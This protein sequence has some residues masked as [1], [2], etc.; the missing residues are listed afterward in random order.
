MAIVCKDSIKRKLKNGKVRIGY[1][2][3]D[4]LK[5]NLDYE[6]KRINKNWDAVILYD[7]EEGAAKTT[8]AC[9]NAYY[10]AEQCGSHF[11]INNIVFTQ[12]EFM[13]LV[14]VAKPY[15]NIVWD[16]FVLSGLNLEALSMLQITL[17]KKMTVIRKKRLVI[18]LIIPYMYMLTKY[19]AVA[20]TR[21]LIHVYSKDNLNR[22]DFLYF[23]KPRKRKLYIMGKKFWEYNVK[24]DFNGNFTNTFGLFFDE[25]EYE[26]RKDEATQK[27]T[28]D[29]RQQRAGETVFKALL[30]FINELG[31]T[32]ERIAKILG[33]TS[34]KGVEYYLK[35]YSKDIVNYQN[36]SER[37]V[38]RKDGS[39][40]III[41]QD[42]TKER[43]GSQQRRVL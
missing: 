10:L 41:N 5:E 26:K 6:I 36:T 17:I 22:G 16:E 7:G 25:E 9:A 8:V 19:F 2:M 23:N 32:H 27:I 31:Y 40:N 15:T 34:H 24:A 28:H 37:G 38:L 33:W 39:G 42:T 21:C 29:F 11:D 43:G 20:R 30:Y 3:H 14:D 18:H 12:T 1:Y 4:L 13:R 35:R